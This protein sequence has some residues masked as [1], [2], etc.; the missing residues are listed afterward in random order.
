ME[1]KAEMESWIVHIPDDYRR[2]FD[3]TIFEMAI[4]L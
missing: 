1:R 3:E 4:S 2:A